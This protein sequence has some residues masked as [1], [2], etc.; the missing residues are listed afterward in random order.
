VAPIPI[1]APT[2]KFGITE[3]AAA[4]VPSTNEMALAAKEP[5]QM[6]GRA[7]RPRMI[8]A[9]RAIPAAGKTGETSPGGDREQKTRLG[10]QRVQGGDR[11][12][13]PNPID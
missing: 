11:Q 4:T 2:S 7:L 13:M 3:W 1:N 8:A 6:P 5:S 10:H 12:Y 9:A